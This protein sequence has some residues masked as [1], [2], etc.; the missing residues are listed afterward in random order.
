MFDL[1]KAYKA[2]PPDKQAEINKLHDIAIGHL[3][4]IPNEGPQ[5]M[6]YLSKADVIYYGGAAG[7]GKTDLLLGLAFNEHMRSRVYRKQAVELGGLEERS[8]EIMGDRK[9]YRG[10]NDK[11]WTL[12]D[13]AQTIEFGHMQRPGDEQKYQGRARDFMGFDEAAQFL[14]EQVRFVT[15]WVRS[16]KSGQRTRIVLASNPPLTAEG[17][18]LIRW[19]APWID[20]DWKG[21]KAEPGEIRWAV[22]IDG[23]IIWLDH[24]GDGRPDD[25]ELDGQIYEPRS[26]TFIPAALDDNPDLRNTPYRAQLNALREPMRSKMLYGNFSRI[27]EDAPNQ[28][29]PSAWVHLAQDRWDEQGWRSSP[30]TALGVDVAQ[31][32]QDRTVLCARHDWWFAEPLIYP[33]VDTPTGKEIVGLVAM[34]I[35]DKAS[36]NI[37]TGGGYGNDAFHRMQEQGVNVIPM[38][39]Q[40]K[41]E[42]ND[43]SGLLKFGNKRAEWWWGLMEALDPKSG[44][45]LALPPGRDVFIDLVAPRYEVRAQNRIQIESKADIRDRLGHSPDIGDAI[46]YAYAE[47]GDVI[48]SV[49]EF[50]RP[51]KGH[52]RQVRAVGGRVARKTAR[53]SKHRLPVFRA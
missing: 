30:M 48:G 19:F 27:T 51:T 39:S 14:E 50:K 29:I 36:I 53:V 22:H 42:G 7:G 2:L 46:V 15:G 44:V 33:G 21:E 20:E 35:R 9:G 3:R 25:Y 23:D 41:S 43:K 32:G 1:V 34:N 52:N 37:D 5:T 26:Y 17:E 4:W 40:G 18:W 38:V 49:E 31:G 11:Q 28:L 13:G 10:G 16:T 45:G 12:K 47:G 24:D 6:A 8:I